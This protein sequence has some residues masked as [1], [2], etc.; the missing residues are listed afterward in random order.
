MQIPSRSSELWGARG[1]EALPRPPLDPPADEAAREHHGPFEANPGG[2]HAAGG[3]QRRRRFSFRPPPPAAGWHPGEPRTRQGLDCGAAVAGLHADTA[4]AGSGTLPLLPLTPYRPPP[5]CSPGPAARL[6]GGARP[7]HHPAPGGQRAGDGR[8]GQ[9]AALRAPRGRRRRR[10][11][12]RRRVRQCRQAGRAAPAQGCARGACRKAGRRHGHIQSA[13]PAAPLQRSHCARPR[14]RRRRPLLFR[15]ARSPPCACPPPGPAP[16]AGIKYA[17]PDY[18][19]SV[20]WAPND[21]LLRAQWHH[22]AVRSGD[23]WNA[24]VGR[25]EVRVCHLDSGVRVDHPDLA[26]RV[27]GG[28]NLVPEVQASAGACRA[29]GLRLSRAAGRR[30]PAALPP[31]CCS[32]FL[33]SFPPACAGVRPGVRAP[34]LPSLPQLQ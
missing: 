6:P 8:G 9:R 12:H 24:S 5:S 3:V 33:S 21:A 1:A 15:P 29:A 2:G 19:V 10:L 4:T 20:N 17:E 27:V 31:P 30:M 11:P 18:R 34:R 22:G 16:G 13:S 32:G 26:G 14:R 7:P 25:P 23:A 28:W